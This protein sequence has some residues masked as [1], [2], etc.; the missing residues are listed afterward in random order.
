[1][2]RD[3]LLRAIRERVHY[4]ATARE[5]MRLLDIP[6]EQR[7]TVRRHLKSLADEGALVMVRGR[8]YGVADRM[9]L[10][11]GRLETHPAGYGFVTPER[12]LEAVKGDV[13][14]AAANLKEALHGDRV[15]VRIEAH[16]ADG[17]AEGRIVRVL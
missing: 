12:Q 2:S 4:P 7:T 5:L 14:I 16:R 13:F 10:V 6:R 17:R 1:M 3:E 11:V 8:R 9:D 15:L